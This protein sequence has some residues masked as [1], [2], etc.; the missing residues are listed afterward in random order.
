MFKRRITEV[1]PETWFL[2]VLSFVLMNIAK[3]I[4]LKLLQVL[5]EV[6][7]RKK[8]IQ[9]RD[10]LDW[11]SIDER[12][13]VIIK[14]FLPI[15][16]LIELQQLL[17]KIFQPFIDIVALLAAITF[18]IGIIGFILLILDAALS[19]I[20]GGSFGRSM[21]VSKFIRAAETLSI[22]PIL[23]F[24]IYVLSSLG[25]PEITAVAQI[26]DNLLKRGWQL[27]LASFSG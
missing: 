27:I 20:T 7:V 9:S 8:T 3:R 23:F 24:I 18:G 1:F 25:F 17:T 15:T 26:M 6:Q 11:K 14:P 13:H 4:K 10:Y 2:K 22:I 16:F 5:Y 19:W 12:L 21:A